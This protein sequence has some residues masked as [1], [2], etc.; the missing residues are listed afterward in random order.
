M[1]GSLALNLNERRL[2]K[3]VESIQVYD[4]NLSPCKWFSSRIFIPRIFLHIFQSTKFFIVN[5]FPSNFSFSVFL[6]TQIFSSRIFDLRVFI[7]EK[8]S[9]SKFCSKWVSPITNFLINKF[10][11]LE[12]FSPLKYFYPLIF[13]PVYSFH[14]EF[15]KPQMF[16]WILLSQ[17][18]FL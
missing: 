16:H 18:F 5:I 12:S 14:P 2:R 10:F 15:D 3:R 8:V 13:H 17:K 11:H 6:T 7:L 4:M 9:S 1:S